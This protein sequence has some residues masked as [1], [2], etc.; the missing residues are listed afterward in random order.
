MRLRSNSP[1]RSSTTRS[2]RKTSWQ[3]ILFGR[4]WRRLQPSPVRGEPSPKPTIGF[5]S[6]TVCGAEN[7]ATK[8]TERHKKTAEIAKDAEIR[9]PCG[10][11]FQ[12]VLFSADFAPLWLN[13]RS[14]LLTAYETAETR[15]PQRRMAG[16][17][18][19][20]RVFLWLFRIGFLVPLV[21]S[22]H[23]LSVFYRIDL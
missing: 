23:H 18:V 22:L 17:F 4:M 15:K 2:N 14:L 11:R 20:F 21:S 8:G 7:F 12:R 16:F 6:F 13:L 5:R 10:F 19:H 9:K 1:P 3:P